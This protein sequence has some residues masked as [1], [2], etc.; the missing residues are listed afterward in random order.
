AGEKPAGARAGENCPSATD[1]EGPPDEAP[2]PG[3]AAANP[4]ACTWLNPPTVVPMPA[5]PVPKPALRTSP[6]AERA[7]AAA[8][9]AANWPISGAGTGFPGCG[10]SPAG[11]PN[12]PVTTFRTG[13]ST[14]AAGGG[15]GGAGDTRTAITGGGASP[16][17]RRGGEGSGGGA[18]AGA[19]RSSVNRAR[20]GR[21]GIR[22]AGAITIGRGGRRGSAGAM[23][24]GR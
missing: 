24:G 13:A 1:G 3:L 6:A 14:P 16:A 4:P 12:R 8:G 17:S 9:L 18:G 10:A 2:P 23:R 15:S 21:G 5:G 20:H 7:G 19:R 22:T 11:A